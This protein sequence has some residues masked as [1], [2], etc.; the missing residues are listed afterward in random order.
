[1]A[2][3]I[4]SRKGSLI[5]RLKLEEKPITLVLGSAI[6]RKH[7]GVG[8]ADVNEINTHIGDFLTKKGLKSNYNEFLDDNELSDNYQSGFEFI[9]S[10]LGQDSI[11][12][13]ITEIVL[14]NVDPVNN[15]HRIT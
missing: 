10:V 2:K 8:I 13:I 11:N 15:N 14:S 1:M 5:Q 4:I 3:R 6:S 9:A 7:N 12:A